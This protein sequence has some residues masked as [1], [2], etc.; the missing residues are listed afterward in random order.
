MTDLETIL[1]WFQTGDLPTEEEFQETFSSFRHKN[2][3]L[4]IAE[5]DGLELSLNNKVNVGD[6]IGGGGDFIPL[7]GTQLNKPVTGHI[8]MQQAEIY[9]PR[10][11]MGD[12]DNDNYRSLQFSLDDE[13]TLKNVNGYDNHGEVGSTVVV[14]RGTI[15]LL[16]NSSSGGNLSIGNGGV[17][18]SSISSLYIGDGIMMNG[19]TNAESDPTFTRQLVQKENG[20]IGFEPKS[21]EFITVP[22][23][24]NGKESRTIFSKNA[25]RGDIGFMHIKGLFTIPANSRILFT[26]PMNVKVNTQEI[27]VFNS[28]TGQVIT[29]L[30]VYSGNDGTTNIFNSTDQEI[31]VSLNHIL[32]GIMD[33]YAE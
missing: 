16:V 31:E 5:V 2:T 30:V 20:S 25:V 17:N 32:I 19:L 23:Y 7:S 10:I 21:P 29:R 9:E 1:S 24:E 15:N 13:I 3:K 14:G 33:N 22:S 18:I 6:I 26:C 8:E 12:L 28:Y 4:Q 11:Y 27:L